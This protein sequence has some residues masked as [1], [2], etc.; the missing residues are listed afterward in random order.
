MKHIKIYLNFLRYKLIY[1]YYSLILR[2][3][4]KMK[5]NDDSLYD[6]KVLPACKDAILKN[7]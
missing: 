4:Y 1:L 3:K 6:M 7:N 2:F 5:P